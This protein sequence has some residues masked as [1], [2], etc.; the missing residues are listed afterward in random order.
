MKHDYDYVY[1][2]YRYRL[3]VVNI[4]FLGG[5]CVLYR[6]VCKVFD[7]GKCIMR[8]GPWTLIRDFFWAK[9]HGAV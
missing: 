1:V 8:G 7:A 5:S 2:L 4:R 3:Y 9:T 6:P